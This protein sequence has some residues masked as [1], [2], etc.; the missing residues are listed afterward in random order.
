MKPRDTTKNAKSLTPLFRG[1][2]KFGQDGDWCSEIEHGT[3]PY[4][5][6]SQSIKDSW[7][8]CSSI[9]VPTN[10]AK[11]LTPLFRGTAKFGQDGD[12]C[13]TIADV[14]IPYSN[15]SQSI[16]DSWFVSSSILVPTKNAKSL[17]PLFRGTAKFGRDRDRCSESIGGYLET[18]YYEILA[19]IGAKLTRTVLRAA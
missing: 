14:T 10:N 2:A 6:C 11:S 8:V 13:S 17:T 4:S 18:G 15:C 16:K 19:Q 1:T 12:W 7:F 5:N 9:L 3:I